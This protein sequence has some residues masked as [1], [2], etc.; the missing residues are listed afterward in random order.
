MKPPVL[1]HETPFNADLAIV[2]THIHL[3]DLWGYDFFA[4]ELLAEIAASGHKVEATIYAEC[5]MRYHT[6]GPEE[7]RPVGE[8]IHA[9]EQAKLAE[10]SPVRIN[11]AIMGAG[12][13][14]IGA[15]L[16]QVMEAHVAAGEGRFRGI[17][18]RGAWDPDPTVRYDQEHGYPDR[19]VL[20]EPEILEAAKVLEDMG[21]VMGNWIFHTQLGQLAT[22]AGKVPGLV[23]TLNHLAGPLGIGP[24]KARRDE[25]FRDWRAGLKTIAQHP[26]VYM[27][28]G[29]LGGTRL[30]YPS[31]ETGASS[32][33]LVRDWKDH[34]DVVI[35]TFGPDRIVF[36]SNFPVDRR[37]APYGNYVNAVKRMIADLTPEEQV[38]IMSGNA[39]RVYRID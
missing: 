23:M 11:A 14:R 29:G 36:D 4:P 22:L 20:G 39:K 19:E 28:L 27:Q 1:I 15:R 12:D 10:G 3:W 13:M 16:R 31:S 9:V 37:I 6:T 21:L 32:D 7:L 8:T 5:D 30:G 18:Y 34:V 38:K 2:D 33:Q 25:V 35:E 17:R 24:Y 26:N